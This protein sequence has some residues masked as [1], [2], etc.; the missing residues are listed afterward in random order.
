MTGP[1]MTSDTRDDLSLDIRGESAG[2]REKRRLT[3]KG[4]SK[5]YHSLTTHAMNGHRVTGT[6]IC[7]WGTPETL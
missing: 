7:N 6:D 4:R 1:A 3:L 2:H 5:S